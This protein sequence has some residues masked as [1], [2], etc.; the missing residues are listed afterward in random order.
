MIQKYVV[1]HDFF[2]L[3]SS[4][5][6]FSNV[7]KDSKKN[8]MWFC[9][10]KFVVFYYHMMIFFIFWSTC[11]IFCYPWCWR[12]APAT[13][14]AWGHRQREPQMLLAHPIGLQYN[15]KLD[16]RK[17]V[18]WTW[19]WRLLEMRM[20][21]RQFIGHEDCRILERSIAERQYIGYE[22]W[23]LLEMRMT[24]RMAVYWTWGLQKIINEDFRI[25]DIGNE[26]NRVLDRR[27]AD[28]R[29]KS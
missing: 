22:D 1:S 29:N 24:D 27:T 28:D 18:H 9:L 6:Y 4:S 19:G 7:C 12:P 8:H 16:S 20:T 11:C 13:S 3:L 5:L 15:R 21:E 26:D 2:Y 10:A 25:W 14:V 23:R 17:E